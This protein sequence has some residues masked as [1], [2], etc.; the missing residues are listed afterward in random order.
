[1]EQKPSVFK[2][3]PF[4]LKRI[5][6]KG[7]RNHSQLMCLRV[8]IRDELLGEKLSLKSCRQTQRTDKCHLKPSLAGEICTYS[9]EII[10]TAY[11]LQ[12]ICFI[13]KIK[14]LLCETLLRRHGKKNPSNDVR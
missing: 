13:F 5:N 6:D 8:H 1:M 4:G 11:T 7:D 3:F 9:N 10:G 2:T 12:F 14:M